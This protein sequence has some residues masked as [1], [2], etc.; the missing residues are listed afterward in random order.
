M[1][2]WQVLLF[3]FAIIY[4]LITR[5]R[6][7]LYNIDYKKSFSFER[8]VISVGNLSVGGTGKTPMI[9]YLA[10]HLISRGKSVAIL[11]RGYG[12]KTKGFRIC[13]EEDNAA[14]V[15]DESFTYFENYREKVMVAV[16]EDRAIA[17]PFI[18]AEKPD[19]D[20]ILLDDA[21]QHRSVKPSFSILLTT[22]ERPF[23]RDFV[24][25]SGRLRE[26]RNGADRADV[27]VVTKSP[28][29]IEHEELDKLGKPHFQTKISYG[30][31]VAFSEGHL[32]KKVVAV[33]GLA[34]NDPFMEYLQKEYYV[35]KTFSFGDHYSYSI[36]DVAS[37][38]EFMK[39]EEASLI[40]TH[41]DAVKLQGFEELKPFG[42]YYLPINV[43]FL[44]NEEH[45]LQMVDESLKDYSLNQ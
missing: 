27:V 6:N 16:G 29:K 35:V 39:R 22:F 7:H 36:K 31:P 23:W 10:D 38:V 18:L 34:N 4:D 19:L 30:N 15:G 40:T 24:M 9:M 25:P 5:F 14:T 43:A 26:A 11:S 33:A 28:K 17:I 3:P 21:F 45:F 42:C 20:V 2:W 41:K 12:R 1:N 8:N 32:H 13:S 44:E 37:M